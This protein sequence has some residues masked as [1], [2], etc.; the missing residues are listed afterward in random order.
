MDTASAVCCAE[1][2]LVG[3]GVPLLVLYAYTAE[4]PTAGLSSALLSLILPLSPQCAS[5]PSTSSKP[6]LSLV[7]QVT[8]LQY[9]GLSSIFVFD[10]Y[11]F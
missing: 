7:T 10:N 2:S 11:N 3:H 9:L 6:H 8:K 1:Q 4:R 5:S